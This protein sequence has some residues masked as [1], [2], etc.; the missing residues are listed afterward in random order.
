MLAASKGGSLTSNVATADASLTSTLD[1]VDRSPLP[2]AVLEVPHGVICA[3]SASALDVIGQDRSVVGRPVT[4]IDATAL[5]GGF[6]LVRSGRVT[7][8]DTTRV[9]SGEGGSRTARV[10]VRALPGPPPVRHVLTVFSRTDELRAGLRAMDPTGAAKTAV[11]GTTDGV[12]HV[13]RVSADVQRVLGAPPDEVLGQPVLRFFA[14]AETGALLAAIGE[15]ASSG[16][17]VSVRSTARRVDGAPVPVAL[18]IVPLAPAPSFAFALAEADEPTGE[19][20]VLD[21]LVERVA[22]IVECT[23]VSRDLAERSRPTPGLERLTTRELHIVARLLEGD[24]VPAIARSLYLS[25]STVRNHL[26]SV[27]AKMRVGSQQELIA[28]L[29]SKR[30]ASSRA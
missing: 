8:Y 24:R 23:E 19:G 25:Q 1:A 20:G 16:R 12:L 28:L 10:W 13:D 11:I 22:Q 5:S 18:T 9:F 29:R 30:D 7:G 6:E 21:H 15:A 2:I 27:F 17:G 4:E 14:E 3:I 26:S